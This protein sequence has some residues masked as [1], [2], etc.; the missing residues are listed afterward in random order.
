MNVNLPAV[1]EAEIMETIEQ[2]GLP[3]AR[4]VASALQYFASLPRDKQ[5]SAYLKTTEKYYI[6]GVKNK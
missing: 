1:L 2:L 4:Y 6:E 3:K 5:L